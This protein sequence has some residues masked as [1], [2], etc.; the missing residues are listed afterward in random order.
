MNSEYYLKFFLCVLLFG[1][2]IISPKILTANA[3]V[4]ELSFNEES[5]TVSLQLMEE[6][7]VLLYKNQEIEKEIPLWVSILPPLIAIFL[8]LVFREVHVAL[9]AGIWLGVFALNGFLWENFLLSLMQVADTYLLQSIVPPDGDLG[10]VSVIVFSLLIGGMVAIISNNG[11]MQDVVYKVSKIATNARRSQLATWLMGTLIFFDDYANTLVVGNTMRPL[12][13]KFKV[14]REKLAYIVDSTAAPVATIAFI[15][16]W[17][18][19][20]LSEINKGI[21]IQNFVA[22]SDGAYSLFLGSLKYAYYPI[23][24]LFFVLIL[25]LFKKDF[26]PMLK[27]E[28]AAQ[29]NNEKKE[30][31][32]ESNE[33]SLA[34]LNAVIPVMSLVFTVILGIF[35]TGK[36][37]TFLEFENVENFNSWHASNSWF[38]IMQTYVGNADSFKALLWGSVVSCIVAVFMSVG[39][40]TLSL[41]ESLE[42]LIEGM[43]TMMPAVVILVLAWSLSLVIDELHTSFYLINLLPENVNIQWFPI[44]FF[45]L[46]ALMAF[47]TGSS[48]STMAIMYPICIPLVLGATVSS[49]LD[50][51]PEIFM[52]VLLNTISVILT[53]SVLGDHCSPIS[54]TTILSSL[55]TQC[56]HVAH[57][58]TQLPYAL[59]VGAVSILTGGVFFAIGVP[60]YIGYLIGFVALFGVVYFLGK[61]VDRK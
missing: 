48:W 9:F 12:T 24:T 28:N 25:I 1:V 13:D 11:G 35:I 58:R 54:D 18:G 29:N 23:F 42:Q 16:T 37:I 61:E 40:R 50:A 15:T 56:D 19:F 45:I 8:A 30:A 38:Q 47:S 41:K 59:I 2:L 34:W 43:K 53:G 26:G 51:Q 55:S 17:I 27:A 4:Q 7:Q 3:G 20:Q 22:I 5:S 57:V 32:G 46:A 10:H 14:S 60:W 36:S 49:G 21:E 52:P 44:L 39:A 33:N 31:L 6:E